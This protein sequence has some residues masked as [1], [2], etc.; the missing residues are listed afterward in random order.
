MLK[1]QQLEALD[2]SLLKLFSKI[3]RNQPPTP[4]NIPDWQKEAKKILDGSSL[5]QLPDY[6]SSWEEM[7]E[8]LGCFPT[9]PF[10]HLGQKNYCPATTAKQRTALH[11]TY[12]ALAC[13][14]LSET[15][16]DGKVA[17]ENLKTKLG[18]Y[19]ERK[20]LYDTF[21]PTKKTD[22]KIGKINAALAILQRHPDW[23]NKQIAEKVVCHVKTLS[24][25][26]R[27][28][29]AKKAIKEIGRED[30]LKAKKHRGRD[31]DAYSDDEE[32]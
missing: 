1:P 13:Y 26:D 9:A 16:E 30:L 2:N 22:E 20:G 11:E 5:I 10:D 18:S 4:A 32:T 14:A 8:G 23:T 12:E 27:F 25:S 29:T 19:L 3:Q 21:R 17:L 7:W 24:N 15:L 6:W 28:A 31:M